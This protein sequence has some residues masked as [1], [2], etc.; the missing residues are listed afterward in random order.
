[1]LLDESDELTFICVIFESE[2]LTEISHRFSPS[3]SL[4]VEFM[5]GK[6]TSWKEFMEEKPL[7]SSAELTLPVVV[8]S[9]EHFLDVIEEMLFR[10][11]LLMM[12]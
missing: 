4:T 10:F 3:E 2:L 12:Q 5:I 11:S 7:S 1:M 6:P 8:F 9:D